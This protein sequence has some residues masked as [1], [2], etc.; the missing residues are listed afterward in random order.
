MSEYIEH[1]REGV[2]VGLVEKKFFLLRRLRMKWYWK[3][4][5]GSAR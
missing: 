5:A 3:A 1:D 4:A 2:S